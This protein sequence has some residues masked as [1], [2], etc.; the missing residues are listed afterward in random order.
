MSKLTLTIE[1]NLQGIRVVRAFAAYAFE[2]GK[3]D[4]AAS[5]ALELANRRLVV[6]F[7]GVAWMMGAYYASMLWLLWV[8]GGRVTAGEMTVGK[9]AEFLTYLTMLQM[10]IRMIAMIVA[11]WRAPPRAVRACSKSSTWSRPFATSPAR[12]ILSSREG[13]LR[14][15][16]VE[17]RL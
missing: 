14:F 10:P 8:G 17:L 2:M 12:Q 9:L 1:E 6:R 4:V 16:H 11:A 3:F 5:R 15:E 7:S 13:V